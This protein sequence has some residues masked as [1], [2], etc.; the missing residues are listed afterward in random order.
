M[1]RVRI[2]VWSLLLVLGMLSGRA[3]AD[4]VRVFKP[5][6]ENM[7]AMYLRSQALAEGFAQA[8]LDEARK[9]LPGTLDDN[10][11]ELLREYLIDHAR[12]YIQGYKILSSEASE[13]GLILRLDVQVNKTNLR[14]GLKRMGF[15][16]TLSA[17]VSASVVLPEDLDEEA[18]ATA[19]NLV[20]LTGLRIEEGALPQFTLEHGRDKGTYKGRLESDEREWMGVSKDIPTLWFDLWGRY[21]SQSGDA[22]VRIELHSLSVAGWFS[23]DGVLEFDRVLRGWDSSV[24]DVR[25]VEMDMQPSGVGATWTFRQLDGDRLTMLLRGFLPQRGLSFKLAGGAKK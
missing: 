23:P 6:E 14:E 16:E 20:T 22:G 2:L 13:A 11:S 17:P 24:Q 4:E 8:V 12:P 5:M 1:S 19:G 3:A 18:L 7:S 21:F 25:L 15:M 9:V 10:R